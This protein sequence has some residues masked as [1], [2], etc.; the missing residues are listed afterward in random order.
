MHQYKFGWT[1]LAGLCGAVVLSVSAGSTTP[2]REVHEFRTSIRAEVLRLDHHFRAV[3]QELLTRDVSSLSAPQ[4]AARLRT[5]E[6]LRQYRE[7]AVFPHN[8]DDVGRR[9]PYFRDEHGTLCAMAYLIAASG[10][11]DIV[12]HIARTNNQVYMREL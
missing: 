9:V 12:N 11:A 6:W 1:A 8:H 10:G 4:R 2:S 3:E 7:A 5:I